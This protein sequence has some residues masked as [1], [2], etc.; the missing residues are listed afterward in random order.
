MSL[1]VRPWSRQWHT[2]WLSK[3]FGLDITA[4]DHNFWTPNPS[5]SSKVSKDPDCGLVPNKNFSEILPSNGLG[6]GEVGQGDLI[7]LYLWCHSQKIC[8]PNQ[9]NFSSAYYKTCQV[10]WVFDQVCS[11]YQTR[12]TPAQNHVQSCCFR[13]SWINPDVK[14][15]KV[16]I[17]N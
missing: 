1:N 9:K 11:A 7:V 14:V 2:F 12:E 15:L 13:E 17:Y 8:T 3:P 5:R 4:L 10:F 16:N 6:P